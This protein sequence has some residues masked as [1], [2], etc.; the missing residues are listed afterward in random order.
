MVHGSWSPG[1]GAQSARPRLRVSA[2]VLVPA[3]HLGSRRPL[4]CPRPVPPVTRTSTGAVP[5]VRARQRRP[6]GGRCG[7]GSPSMPRGMI[8][9][10]K[11]IVRD[12]FYSAGHDRDRNGLAGGRWCCDGMVRRAFADRGGCAGWAHRGVVG[13]DRGGP[14]GDGHAGAAGL[15]GARAGGVGGRAG[16]WAGRGSCCAAAAERGVRVREPVCGAV[17]L[18]AGAGLRAWAGRWFG[19]SVAA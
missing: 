10:R 17:V 19:G 4:V 2:V 16:S 5:E 13:R 8:T 11:G 9:I 12:G 6:H 7:R 15:R 3:Q 14:A 18:A 1:S